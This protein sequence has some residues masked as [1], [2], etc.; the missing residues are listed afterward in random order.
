RIVRSASKQADI[1]ALE[2][3]VFHRSPGNGE[4]IN[5]G[6]RSFDDVLRLVKAGAKFKEWL[7]KS[8]EDASLVKE[9]CREVT[10]ADWAEHLPPKAARW[11]V[12]AAASTV[13]RL[14][15]APAA[16]PARGLG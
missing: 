14:V 2:N 15:L 5:G 13:A 12:F 16:G 11:A 1:K 3:L 10:R 8:P 7:K 6:Q 9:Y 4:A